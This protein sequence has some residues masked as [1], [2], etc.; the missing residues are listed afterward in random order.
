MWYANEQSTHFQIICT[1][2]EYTSAHLFCEK[3]W[4]ETL[5]HDNSALRYCAAR[6][7]RRSAEPRFG[8]FHVGW[9]SF[10]TIAGNNATICSKNGTMSGFDLNPTREEVAGTLLSL[11][12]LTLL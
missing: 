7:Q 4:L 9:P 6:D 1:P 10:R 8:L 11:V 12:Y 3:S 2:L 5:A